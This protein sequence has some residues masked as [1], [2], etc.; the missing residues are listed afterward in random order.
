MNYK[1]IN[2]NLVLSKL[3]TEPYSIFLMKYGFEE[4]GF[5]I[6]YSINIQ[7]NK[8][9]TYFSMPWNSKYDSLHQTH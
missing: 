6:L 2:T 7:K 9:Y 5:E 8:N 4:E 1:R 3:L